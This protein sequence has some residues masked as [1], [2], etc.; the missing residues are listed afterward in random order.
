MP[1]DIVRFEL[2]HLTLVDCQLGAFL[3]IPDLGLFR[4][5]YTRLAVAE[6]FSIDQEPKLLKEK[7]GESFPVGLSHQTLPS[8]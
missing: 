4:V 5:P 6:Q 2:K 8:A 1:H 3:K 7:A